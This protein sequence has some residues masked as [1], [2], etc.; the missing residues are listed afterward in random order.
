MSRVLIDATMQAPHTSSTSHPKS[1]LHFSFFSIDFGQDR[2][3]SH[4]R[5]K[6]TPLLSHWSCLNSYL[7][8]DRRTLPQNLKRLDCLRTFC[9]QNYILVSYRVV[10]YLIKNSLVIDFLKYSRTFVCFSEMR[11][12]PVCKADV[13]HFDVTSVLGCCCFFFVCVFLA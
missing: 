5:S 6:T 8:S 4:I 7:S 1:A 10:V 9:L 13:R 3:C 2:T 12:W 11:V